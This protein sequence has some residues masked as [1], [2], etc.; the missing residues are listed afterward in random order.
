MTATDELRPCPFC[1]RQTAKPKSSGR[2]GWF[3]GCSCHAVGP[4]ADT[5]EQAI[6][7][8]NR[9]VEPMQTRLELA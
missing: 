9:R 7:L 4:N 3:V 8:W 1:G 5:K 2:W 6:E